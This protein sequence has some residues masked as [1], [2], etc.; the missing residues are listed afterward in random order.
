[1]KSVSTSG[2][3]DMVDK[4]DRVTYVLE[5]FV[6]L[7][8]DVAR[9]SSVVPRDAHEVGQQTLLHCLLT[10]KEWHAKG[11]C[12]L[13]DSIEHTSI[14]LPLREVY[15]RVYTSLSSKELHEKYR[16][17]CVAVYDS[18]T[19]L[20]KKLDISTTLAMRVKS[21]EFGGFVIGTAETMK[22]LCD[23]LP[24]CKN[25]ESL[26]SDNFGSKYSSDIIVK[27]IGHKNIRNLRL[28]KLARRS[29]K[30]E[31]ICQLR[32]GLSLVRSLPRL[33]SFLF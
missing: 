2:V 4:G 16:Y 23:I 25:L 3:G 6:Q 19:S 9:R 30:R 26:I 1:M 28:R 8:V 14:S 15:R 29:K 17:A 5:E 11:L 20:F 22:L 31:V 32:D 7:L 10:C 21:M 12:F 13:R 24:K 27:L 33:K 18:F